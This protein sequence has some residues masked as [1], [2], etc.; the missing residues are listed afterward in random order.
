MID[1]FL[2]GRQWLVEVVAD[3]C[4]FLIGF[5]VLD[6]FINCCSFVKLYYSQFIQMSKV[7][8]YHLK[9]RGGSITPLGLGTTASFH[10]F[11]IGLLSLFS[12]LLAGRLRLINRY[13]TSLGPSIT[14]FLRV[15]LNKYSL[16]NRLNK[17]ILLDPLSFLDF[18]DVG[19]E[20]YFRSFEKVHPNKFG[21]TL[22][23]VSGA[24]LWKA[25]V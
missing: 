17:S 5:A 14:T 16:S 20:L 2:L 6:C 18:G 12:C 9:L 10:I 19:A 8:Y 13:L 15:V 24:S 21:M 22:S 23:W 7:R 4:F 11:V 1:D 25:R 3:C